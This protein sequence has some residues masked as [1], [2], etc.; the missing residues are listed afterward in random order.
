[1]YVILKDEDEGKIGRR[2]GSMNT[3]ICTRRI[4]KCIE[5]EFVGRFRIRKSRIWVSGRIHVRT[6]ERIWRKG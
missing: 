2:T 5:R 1:M 4:G 6:K 3:I